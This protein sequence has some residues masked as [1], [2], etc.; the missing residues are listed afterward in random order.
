MILFPQ[1]FKEFETNPG[2]C[3]RIPQNQYV[4]YNPVAFLPG[5]MHA[6]PLTPVF[7]FPRGIIE[8][9]QCNCEPTLPIPLALKSAR[10]TVTQFKHLD[11]METLVLQNLCRELPIVFF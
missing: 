2:L 11:T 10:D 7:C 8:K 3:C 5:G 1:V 9:R 6:V 4:F